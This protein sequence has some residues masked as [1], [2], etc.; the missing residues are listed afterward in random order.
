MGIR[1][2]ILGLRRS[3]TTVFWESFRGDSRL[4]CYD[5]PFNPVLNQLPDPEPKGTR[6]EWIELFRSN[7]ERFWEVFS[8]IRGIEEL[9]EGF[10]DRQRVYLDY[11]LASAASVVLD[12]T[13]CHFKIEALHRAAPDAHLVH[14]YRPAAAWVSSHLVMRGRGWQ[15]RIR[16]VL[17]RATFFDRDHRFNNWGMEEII[18]RSPETLFGRR[19]ARAGLDPAAVYAMPAVGRMLAYWKIHYEHVER[20]GHRLFGSRFRTLAFTDFCNEPSRVVRDVYAFLGIEPPSLDLPEVHPP[21]GAYRRDDSRWLRFADPL[22]LH[23]GDGLL[24]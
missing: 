2:F 10:S 7:P 12:M 19:L 14:L 22:G 1:L 11:V 15:D 13:R 21:H 5:E 4:V 3:G 18:A 17:D 8:P 23:E 6:D 20:V 9:Q 16:S 24:F